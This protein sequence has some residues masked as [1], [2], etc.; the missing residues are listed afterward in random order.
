MPALPR[1]SRARRWTRRTLQRASGAC[2]ELALGCPV[3]G[4]A[5]DFA[6][7]VLGDLLPE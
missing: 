6:A 3:L 5:L 1:T 4:N 7:R 2:Q